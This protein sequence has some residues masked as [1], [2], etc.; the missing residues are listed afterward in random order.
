MIAGTGTLEPD[1]QVRIQSQNALDLIENPVSGI[2]N[3]DSA[4][5]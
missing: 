4:K 1:A 2:Q 3:P 5:A